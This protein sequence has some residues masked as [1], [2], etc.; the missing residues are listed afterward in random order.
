MT[1]VANG[2]SLIFGRDNAPAPIRLGRSETSTV[3]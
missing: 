1:R 3:V 2:L